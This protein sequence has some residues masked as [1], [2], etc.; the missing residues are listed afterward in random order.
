MP[1]ALAPRC[2]LTQNPGAVHECD[3]TAAVTVHVYLLLVCLM[4]SSMSVSGIRSPIIWHCADR[5]ATVVGRWDGIVDGWAQYDRWYKIHW[6]K[7]IVNSAYTCTSAFFPS[8]LTVSGMNYHSSVTFTP[9]LCI[10]WQ[11]Y[12]DSSF[13]PFVARYSELPVKLLSSSSNT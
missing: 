1:S 11:S 8:L 4:C 3:V 9:S 10:F 6:T 2:P 5:N 12:E 7:I 13:Q